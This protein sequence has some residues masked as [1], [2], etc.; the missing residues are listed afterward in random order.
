[1]H[2]APCW[3]ATAAG[4]NA[5]M[6]VSVHLDDEAIY[7]QTHKG[8]AMAAGG[9]CELDTAARRLLL[10]VNGFTPLRSLVEMV[11]PAGDVRRALEHLV[12]HRLIEL[13]EQPSAH[14]AGTQLR[15]RRSPAAG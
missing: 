14:R 4:H 10:L 8:S 11:E 12:Q 5:V 13:V 6:N 15:P 3:G 1:M 7:G 9:A 2:K